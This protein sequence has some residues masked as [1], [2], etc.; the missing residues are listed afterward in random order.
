VIGA[1]DDRLTDLTKAID[2]GR[3]LLADAPFRDDRS[4]LNIVGDSI[5]NF[6]EGSAAARGR[7]VA[8]SITVNGV[9]TGGSPEVVS[10]YRDYVI[11]GDGAFVMDNADPNTVVDAMARKFLLDVAFA[12]Q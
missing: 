10:Y 6:G 8:A 1:C 3:R 9:V 7:A 5:D 12:I 2:C 11:G 4:V